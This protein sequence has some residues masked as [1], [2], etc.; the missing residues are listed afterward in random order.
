MLFQNYLA[1]EIF[2]INIY[3]HILSRV[4][5]KRLI[6]ADFRWQLYDFISH[7]SFYTPTL[8]ALVDNQF[9][10]AMDKNIIASI[11]A[12]YTYRLHNSY[13]LYSCETRDPLCS[14]SFFYEGAIR[15]YT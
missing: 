15:I 8:Y 3:T 12:A 2:C 13:D 6:T 5:R 4:R 11:S 14:F 7:I 10:N 1:C 9:R